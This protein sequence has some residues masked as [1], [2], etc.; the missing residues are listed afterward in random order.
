MWS[1]QLKSQGQMAR[2]LLNWLLKEPFNDFNVRLVNYI[3][4]IN[5]KPSKLSVP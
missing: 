4:N 5:N 1:A 2:N 3:L